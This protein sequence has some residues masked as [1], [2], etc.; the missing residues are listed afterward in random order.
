MNTTHPEYL[1]VDQFIE[2]LVDA[3]ALTSAIELGLIDYLEAQSRSFDQLTGH[4]KQ[5]ARGLH[6]LLDL[7]MA[8]QVVVQRD[9]AFGLGE[10]FL[11]A[12]RCRDLLEAKLNLANLVATDFIHLFTPLLVD[13]PQFMRKAR[14]FEF[15]DYGRCR[16]DIQENYEHTKRWMRLTTTLT[17]YEAQACVP[18]HDFGRH[19]RM[20][21]IGGNSGEFALQ[22]CRQS[23]GLRATVFDLPVVCRIGRE[24]VATEPEADRIDFVA[25]DASQDQLPTGFDLLTFKSMLHDWPEE[26]AKQFIERADDALAPGG[27]LLIYERQEIELAGSSVPYSLIPM[28]LFFR[29]FRSPQFYCEVLEEMNF[30]DIHVQTINLEMP[31]FLVTAKKADSHGM[32]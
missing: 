28:L 15:F 3:R 12:W 18:Y 16:D 17:K 9:D 19:Q 6:L 7:L 22:I 29:S 2:R 11:A 8:N 5:D 25:G 32:L 1:C 4:F 13:P 27:T 14:L 24:H 31:F 23:P 21:D 20:L 26:L 30:K 10:H